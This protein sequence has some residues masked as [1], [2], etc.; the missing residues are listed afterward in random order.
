[1]SQN[2]QLFDAISDQLPFNQSPRVLS[3]GSHETWLLGF[4]AAFAELD[5]Q[6]DP[7]RHFYVRQSAVADDG[8]RANAGYIIKPDASYVTKAVQTIATIPFPAVD[9][10][11]DRIVVN[12]LTG[13]I[14]RVVGA[15]AA[16]PVAPD[17][18]VA[19]EL[20]A[21]IALT[22]GQTVIVDANIT[23]ERPANISARNIAMPKTLVVGSNANGLG[24]LATH[25]TLQAAHDDAMTTAGWKILVLTG[26]AA[27]ATTVDITEPNILIQFAEGVSYVN[28]G[29][30]DGINIQAAADRCKII[31]GRFTGFTGAAILIDATVDFTMLRDMRFNGNTA[32]VTDNGTGTSSVNH[33]VEP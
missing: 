19:E 4:Q 11:I 25:A 9:P 26:E 22:V 32:D 7:N 6:T 5:R 16:S 23:D 17:P 27:L 33:I 14:N 1:M 2:A 24:M 10:R 18:G 30:G 12:R 20:L 8:I 29:A 21:Q 13:V 3:A 31:G 15:E 28:S